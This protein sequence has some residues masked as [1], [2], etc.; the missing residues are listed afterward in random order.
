ML[1]RLFPRR[2]GH[3]RVVALN[4]RPKRTAWGGGNQFAAQITRSL[5]QHGYTV[6]HDLRG[7]ADLILL[8]EPRKLRL[9]TFGVEEIEAFRRRHPHVKVLHRINEC[10]QRKGTV[11][12]DPIL[13]RA[14]Q[15]AD[16]TVFISDW[17]RAYHAKWYDSAKPQSVIY[18]GAD[19]R[20]FHPLGAA[21]FAEDT[22][23]RVVTHHWSDNALKGFDAYEELDQLIADGALPGFEFHVIGRWPASIQWRAAKT[24]GACHGAALA[25]RLRA[26][27]LYLTASR[28]EPCGMHHVEGVQCGL[29]LVYHLDGGGIVEA[30]ERYG[31]PFRGDL[32]AALRL[33]RDDYATLRRRVFDAMPSGDLMCIEYLRVIQRM[34]AE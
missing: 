18:N 16:R 33:A 8:C 1:A 31:A 12:M 32:A 6:R 19:P 7:P 13:E 28:W 15:C 2:H 26:C 9:V 27:H 34:L 10:D 11:D 4:L 30:G 3:G 29:P 17:L 21:R 14:N 5:L 23:F 22:P 25:A 24:F 20:V